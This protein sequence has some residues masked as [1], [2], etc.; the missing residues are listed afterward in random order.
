MF[1]RHRNLVILTAVLF[2]QLGLLAYQFRKGTDI[3]QI[4][5]GTM[6]VVTPVQR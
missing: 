5:N 6:Y 1:S 4:R 3:P 2:G